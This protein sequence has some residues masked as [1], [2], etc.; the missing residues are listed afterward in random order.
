MSLWKYNSNR[1]RVAMLDLFSVEFAVQCGVNSTGISKRNVS[2][3]VLV[4][5]PPLLLG[6]IFVALRVGERERGWWGEAGKRRAIWPSAA[7]PSHQQCFFLMLLPFQ[8]QLLGA[9]A[10]RPL[11]LSNQP[12]PVPQ[13]WEH[14][15]QSQVSL[16][17]LKIL[18]ILKVF[19]CW[20]T[21]A[22]TDNEWIST[23][24]PGPNEIFN[25]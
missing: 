4:R 10:S 1:S 16:D 22:Q 17:R 13:Q 14:A 24:L 21:F 19:Y 8:T 9:P 23:I 11:T 15:S 18:K 12:E 6:C 20:E 5:R 7:A 3:F 25:F 2:R